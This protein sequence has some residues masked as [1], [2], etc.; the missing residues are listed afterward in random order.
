MDQRAKLIFGNWTTKPPKVRGGDQ[1]QEFDREVAV[2]KYCLAF[3]LLLAISI[4]ASA[5]R[6]GRADAIQN[7]MRGGPAPPELLLQVRV[8]GKRLYFRG[9]DLRKMQRTA[10]T[11]PDPATGTMHAYEGVNFETLIPNTASRSG[12]EIVEVSFGSH[13]TLTILSA[14]LDP[15]TKPMVVDTVDGKRIAAYV[16]FCVIAK[17][18]QNS[19]TLMKDVNL[20]NVKSD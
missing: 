12:L 18:R 9:T 17:T 1:S 19:A 6:H 13:Q 15:A 2:I 3:I 16:P 11:L 5:Q 8:Q 10:V 7:Y 20:I 4:G 14:D